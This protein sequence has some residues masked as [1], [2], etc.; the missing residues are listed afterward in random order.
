MKRL[1]FFAFAVLAATVTLWL[2]GRACYAPSQRHEEDESWPYALGRLS[3]VPKRY[4]SHEASTNAVEVARLAEGVEVDLGQEAVSRARPK[5][6][7]TRALRPAMRKY[8]AGEVNTAS[9]TVEAPPQEIT[10]FLQEHADALTAVRAQLNA[11]APPRSTAI[12][13]ATTPRRGSIST[14]SGSSAAA[15]SP[16]PI[17][18][19]PPAPSPRRR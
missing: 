13:A 5:P 17:G 2:G 16:S 6:S 4:P 3:D 7:R 18:G 14:L 10:R 15:C 8:I 19:A 12:A 1:L 11:N 9:D